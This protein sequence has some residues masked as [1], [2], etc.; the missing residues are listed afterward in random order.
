M[1]VSPSKKILMLK[2]NYGSFR[3]STPGGIID[4]GETP[5]ESAK[6][7]LYEE[8]GSEIDFKI[9]TDINVF[10][11]DAHVT[12]VIFTPQTFNV[13]LSDEH[14]DYCWEYADEI[15][16]GKSDIK[17]TNYMRQGINKAYQSGIL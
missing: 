2:L 9:V 7:E 3:W 4:S 17:I 13:Q 12:Y 5:L 16:S 15:F 10:K 14:T 8:T 6:R 11:H 1:I